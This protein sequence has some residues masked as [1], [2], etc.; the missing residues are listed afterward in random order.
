MVHYLLRDES[1]VDHLV[2]LHAAEAAVFHAVV[3]LVLHQGTLKE[4]AYFL[5]GAVQ[6]LAAGRR[7]QFKFPHFTDMRDL[8]EM[9]NNYVMSH[10]VQ[11]EEV[12]FHFS[13]LHLTL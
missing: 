4:R 13:D 1:V 7:V 10:R 5:Y 3:D 2:F 12:Y 11:F 6:I 9:L 8:L